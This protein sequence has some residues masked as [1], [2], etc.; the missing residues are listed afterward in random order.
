MK[1]NT[2]P[3]LTDL[4]PE[5]TEDV[6]P[7]HI[8]DKDR[9]DNSTKALEKPTNVLTAEAFF[10]IGNL[11][12]EGGKKEEAISAYDQAIYLNPEYAYAHYNRGRTKGSL[13]QYESEIVDL[14]ETLRLKPD[15]AE[16]YLLRGI[17]KTALKNY[18]SAI[19]EFEQNS[20]TEP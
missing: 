10:S 12:F 2:F 18:E 6:N 16:A 20:T 3:K 1:T 7:K 9:H 8:K 4:F 19:A 13:G 15:F 5:L 17:A 11:L 14:D